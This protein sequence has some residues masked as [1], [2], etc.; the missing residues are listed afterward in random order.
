MGFR[1]A[2]GKYRDDAANTGVNTGLGG[3]GGCGPEV[4]S[5]RGVLSA[6][7]KALPPPRS[8]SSIERITRGWGRIGATT[9]LDDGVGGAHDGALEG[10]D[11]LRGLEGDRRGL[12]V[13]SLGISTNPRE[14]RIR[15]AVRF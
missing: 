8:P 10:S 15:T 14:I 2:E 11:L 12:G 1:K 13:G 7:R 5:P 4:P 6:F 9:C 3:L